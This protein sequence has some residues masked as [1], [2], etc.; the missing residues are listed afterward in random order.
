MADQESTFL[1]LIDLSNQGCNDHPLRANHIPV[2]STPAEVEQ[3]S[4]F[5]SD[6]STCPCEKTPLLWLAHIINL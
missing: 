1:P 6:A 2:M 5:V 3:Q 4:L